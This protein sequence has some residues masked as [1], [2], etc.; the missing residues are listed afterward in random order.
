M[1][2]VAPVTNPKA[3]PIVLRLPASSRLP[4]KLVITWHP[5]NVVVMMF[6]APGAPVLS[7]AQANHGDTWLRLQ[8]DEPTAE[9]FLGG[10]SY[11]L[12]AEEAAIVAAYFAPKGLVVSDKP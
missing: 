8:N 2:A 9:L 5:T 3:D 11:D 12:H 6:A 4:R 1:N 10:A 7:V